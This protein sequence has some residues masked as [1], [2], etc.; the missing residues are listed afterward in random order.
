MRFV[1]IT[2]R[3]P[4]LKA[5]FE[6][7]SS[8]ALGSSSSLRYFL[9]DVSAEMVSVFPSAVISMSSFFAPGSSAMTRISFSPRRRPPKAPACRLSTPLHLLARAVPH[10]PE[11]ADNWLPV[12]T[13]RHRVIPIGLSEAGLTSFVTLPSS[14]RFSLTSCPSGRSFSMSPKSMN[15][16]SSSF[17]ISST[18]AYDQEAE[19]HHLSPALEPLV[20]R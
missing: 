18:S 13:D 5:E 12:G 20:C 3:M 19:R 14:A 1:K 7:S 15:S 9:V 16:F 4:L 2:S 10:V 17:I 6:P 11:L 8:T